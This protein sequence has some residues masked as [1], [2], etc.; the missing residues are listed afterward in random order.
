MNE[1]VK[2]LVAKSI[3][4]DETTID[5]S[6]RILHAKGAELT[7]YMAGAHEIK[8]HYFADRVD[9]CSIINAKSG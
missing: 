3:R 2:L 8:E 9:L 7:A 1:K 4:G 5:E 6:R